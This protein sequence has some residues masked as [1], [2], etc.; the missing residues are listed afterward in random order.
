MLETLT[1]SSGV[2]DDAHEH[3]F[4]A[5]GSSKGNPPVKEGLPRLPVFFASPL[6]DYMVC[7]GLL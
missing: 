1:A 2:A 6:T 7:Y 3:A 4:A 5:E